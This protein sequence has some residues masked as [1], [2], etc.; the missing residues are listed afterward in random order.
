MTA[1]QQTIKQL[2]LGIADFGRIVR[3]GYY[4]VDK[5]MFI[6]RLEMA[7]SYLFLVRPRRFGKS[8]LLS[9]LKC[10]YDINLKDRFDEYFGQ[11]WIG[12]HP[13]PYRN[14][15]AVLHLDFSQVTGT[16][17]SLEE[18]F[19]NYCNYALDTFAERYRQLF[20]PGFSETIKAD[21]NVRGK[22]SYIGMQAKEH[23][24]PLY[25]IVDEYDNFTNTVLNQH[26]Q[27]IY[28]G[29]THGEGFYRDIFKLFKPNFERVLMLGVSPVTMDDLT[30]GYNI[31]TN[32]TADAAFNH[33][34]GFSEEEVRQMFR[35]YSEAGQLTEGI[36]AMIEEMKPWYDNYC[37]AKDGLGDSRVFNSNM[38]LYYLSNQLRT[39]HAPDEMADPNAR[40]DYQKMKRLIQLDR[41]EP[42]RKSIIYQIAE[43]GYIYS[44][45]VP[46]F[47]A[48]E[49][50]KFDNFVSLLYYYGMLTISGVRGDKLRLGIPNNN[51]RKQY[52]GY[53][54]EEYDRIRPADR[55][56]IDQAFDSAVFDGD[57]QPLVRAVSDEYEKTCAVRCLIEGE[58]N[59]QGF[60]TAYLTM[61]SYYLIAPELELNHG[62]CDFFLLPDLQR[63][64]M[65]AHS[66]ILE[67]KYLKQDA[68]AEEAEAQWEKAVSQI[69]DYALEPKLR[70]LCGPTQLHLVVAQFRGYQLE[71][72]EEVKASV[73]RGER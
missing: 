67:L 36:D 63:Y 66:Y 40:T 21:R 28:T 5:T 70:L 3:E 47:P 68:S 42:Q 22:L 17:D 69:T 33:L 2:P 14:R 60:F 59:L 34:L 71:R 24:V 13:T 20:G 44:R 15:Y 4:Y 72:T 41:L 51:V 46:Y 11:L 31:A 57:W 30:S 27:D 12:S 55:W 61:T 18:N 62:Y 16:I 6:P 25:L 73:D 10:Y 7:S 43:E 23:D 45:L 65:V 35:Y 29:L 56:R 19:Y 39:S 48:S 26:G 54:L 8:L 9:M 50:V 38:V 32:I 1:M 53:L 64:P 58:R 49:M 37:F 52:Y